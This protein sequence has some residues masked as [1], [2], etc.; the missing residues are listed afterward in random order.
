MKKL[1]FEYGSGLMEALLP[2]NTDVFIPGE[3]VADPPVLADIPGATLAAIR[4]PIG[5]PPISRIGQEGRQGRHRVPGP[6][7]G[8]HPGR[9]APQGVDPAGARRTLRGR[10]GEEGHPPG[11]LERPA[12]QEHP[13][14]DQ[15]PARR[16][17]FQRFLVEPPDHQPRLRGLRQPG[18]SRPG[19]HGQPGDHEQ[20]GP[21]RRLRRHDRPHAW[22]PLR[23]LLRRL[24][25]LRHRDHPLAQHRVPPCSPRHAPR[26][27]S[28]RCPTT[29]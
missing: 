22:Q 20:G 1:A 2:D 28:P 27:T 15:G 4:N 24:Q 21:R 7:Q 9:R 25:T 8:R 3:T 13:G 6:G 17:P 18:G 14:R 16:R 11:V 12:P 19:R 26:A 23:R 5:M 29:A 10:G